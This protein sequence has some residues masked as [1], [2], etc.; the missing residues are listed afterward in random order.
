M[1]PGVN[2][3]VA[4]AATTDNPKITSLMTLA[5]P[6]VVEEARGWIV[7]LW[8]GQRA[9]ALQLESGD[10]ICEDLSSHS[11][12]LWAALRTR[13]QGVAGYARSIQMLAE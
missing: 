10:G 1:P 5:S 4:L 12:L 13:D 9:R 2:E 7:L 6:S 3:A 8:T 11:L